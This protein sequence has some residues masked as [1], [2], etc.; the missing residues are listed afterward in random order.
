METRT[1]DSMTAALDLIDRTAGRIFGA[2][3]EK[4]DGSI[5]TG[6][7]RVEFNWTRTTDNEKLTREYQREVNANVKVLDANVARERGAKAAIRSIRLDRLR[8]I[9]FAGVRYVASY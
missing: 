3:F 5:R 4:A 7:F 2:E 8:S 6:A 9:T 1:L